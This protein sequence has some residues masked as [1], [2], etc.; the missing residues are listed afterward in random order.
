MQKIYGLVEGFFSSPRTM[1][2]AEERGRVI[3]FMASNCPS[4]NTYL[5][6]P[7]DDP[8]VAKKWDKPYP[9]KALK[10]IQQ[11]AAQC[12]NN[13]IE[14]VYGLNPGF[15]SQKICIKLAQLQAIGISSFAILYDDIPYAYNVTG[16]VQSGQDKSMG[17]L[18][19]KT[20][21][22]VRA[23]LGAKTTLLFCPSDYFLS[24]RTDYTR[25][26]FTRLDPVIQV[27]WTGPKIFTPY[28]TERMVKRA[29]QVVGSNQL[30]W[31]DNYPVNDCEHP[32]G[33]FHLGAFNAPDKKVVRQIGGILMNP[34]REPYA[35]FVALQTFE[36][37]SSTGDYSRAKAARK[38]FQR[39]FGDTW[40][41]AYTLCTSFASRS[42]VDRQPQG[43]LKGVLE[44][45]DKPAIA[46]I[47]EKISQDI[48]LL[49]QGGL[50]SATSQGRVLLSNTGI[51]GRAEVYLVLCE[52]ILSGK[53]WEQDFTSLDRFPIV[54]GKFD[55]RNQLL[56]TMRARLALTQGLTHNTTSPQTVLSQLEEIIKKYKGQS[57]Q[58]I[59]ETDKNRFF[60]VL[61]NIIKQDRAAFIKNLSR[62]SSSQKIQTI[63][64]RIISNQYQPG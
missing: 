56:R 1:W 22:A 33:T 11:A 62:L 40:K 57:S 41:S 2:S 34:M 26:L 55:Y 28:I 4:L 19:A 52:K 13:N 60:T 14:F 45:L 36:Y 30:I 20:L 49:K 12:R 17:A 59:T 54:L 50:P 21:N 5:Y 25:A 24:Q 64:K 35:N 31:W 8:F 51:I 42:C 38:A 15:D 6:C 39:L 61:D 23:C 47:L 32:D 58:S 3:S 10:T 43:Y 18:Q 9:A 7:K 48:C 29:Q 53:P 37:F 27:L 16:R 44:A 46:R 63:T